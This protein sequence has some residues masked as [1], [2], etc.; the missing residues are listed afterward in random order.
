MVVTIIDSKEPISCPKNCARGDACM[1]CPVFRSCIKSPAL[2]SAFSWR[3]YEGRGHSLLCAGL[4]DTT[5]DY[6]R[7]DIARLNPR[8]EQLA[9]LTEAADRVQIRLSKSAHAEDAR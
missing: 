8:E 7:N 3:H 4:G 2:T 5:S 6:V 9:D 1:R